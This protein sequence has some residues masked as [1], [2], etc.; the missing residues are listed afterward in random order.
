MKSKRIVVLIALAIAIW[1][2]PAKAQNDVNLVPPQDIVCGDNIEAEFTT[3]R[4]ERTYSITADAGTT[5]TVTIR[6]IAQ[7]PR[8]FALVTD[9]SDFGIAISDGRMDAGQT[10]YFPGTLQSQIQL[11]DLILPATG[12][13]T[14]RLV[15]FVFRNFNFS[16]S[17]Y[18]VS[19]Y[20]GVGGTGLYSILIECINRNGTP[21]P[22]L[23][24]SG[25]DTTQSND[26]PQSPIESILP[27]F[28]IVARIPLILD[29][30]MGGGIS[31]NANSLSAYS[32]EGVK[33][34]QLTLDIKRIA[35]NLNIG[36]IVFS[37]S[38][39]VLSLSSLIGVNNLAVSSILPSDGQYTVG[40]FRLDLL[41][42]STTENTAFQIQASLK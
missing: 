36:V 6:S 25:S 37:P 12:K 7:Q 33:D 35:G 42:P 1:A 39:E 26:T 18:M 9:P 8:M 22:P 15:N 14:L 2:L 30:P 41:S 20:D 31:G 4:E 11:K 16:N 34:Q 13:Y 17:D 21:I 19:P 27:D 3:I 24:D 40:V 38:N 23:E 5:V 32:F 28:S 10:V 29:L